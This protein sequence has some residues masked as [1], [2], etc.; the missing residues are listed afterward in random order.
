V[1][2]IDPDYH[3]AF[4][5]PDDVTVSV[6]RYMDLAKLLGIFLRNELPLVRLD[7]L[8]DEY[9]GMFPDGAQDAFI[10]WLKSCGTV[11]DEDI[12]ANLELP[13]F[14]GQFIVFVS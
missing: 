6:W 8:P 1:P 7:Q 3:L 13:R 4:P 9:E 12:E 14:G 5:Q 11:R 2:K 10:N